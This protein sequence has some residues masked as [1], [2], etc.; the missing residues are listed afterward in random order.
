MD[1]SILV[2][3]QIEEGQQLIGCVADQLLNI[4]IAAWIKESEGRVWRI[5][6][7]VGSPIGQKIKTESVRI[8]LRALERMTDPTIFFID[9]NIIE[10]KN[11][12]T[13]DLLAICKKYPMMVS[14]KLETSR[15]IGHLKVKGLYIYPASF[16]LNPPSEI[17]HSVLLLFDRSGSA[18]ASIVTLKDGSQIHAVP[19][20]IRLNSP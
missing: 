18:S 6:I 16:E 10:A 17:V 3:E 15:Q 11:P 9:I 12:I 5:Y 1:H 14:T 13:L 20:G 8:A 7:A 4:V 2:E 19:V